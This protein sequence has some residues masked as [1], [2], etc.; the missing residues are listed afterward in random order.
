MKLY[1]EDPKQWLL[2]A[3]YD[4]LIAQRVRIVLAALL[5]SLLRNLL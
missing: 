1:Y 4:E 5:F 2:I 3:D